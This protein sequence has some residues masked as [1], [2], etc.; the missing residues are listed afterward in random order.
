MLVFSYKSFLNKSTRNDPFQK[1]LKPKHSIRK[2]IFAYLF[3]IP[4]TIS[5]SRHEQ[6]CL[7]GLRFER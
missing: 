5:L 2:N 1:S 6:V 7:S 4:I 3:S